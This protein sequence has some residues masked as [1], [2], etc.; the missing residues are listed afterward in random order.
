MTPHS[1]PYHLEK[2]LKVLSSFTA[3]SY[4]EYATIDSEKLCI[5]KQI[6]I[7]DVHFNRNVNIC[8]NK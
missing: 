3:E 1:I 6:I 2:T 4:N 7:Y 5:N 8:L